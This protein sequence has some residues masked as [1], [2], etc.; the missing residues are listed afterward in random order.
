MLNLLSLILV[1]YFKFYMITAKTSNQ[2]EQQYYHYLLLFITTK[3]LDNWS[4]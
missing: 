3:H 2:F 4:M 1:S